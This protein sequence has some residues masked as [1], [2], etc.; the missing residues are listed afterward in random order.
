MKSVSNG[1]WR[2]VSAVVA[3]AVSAAAFVGPQVG[4]SPNPNSAETAYV[5]IAPCR[6]VDTRPE[7]QVGRRGSPIGSNETFAQQVT[8]TNG[9]CTIPVDA[10]GVS[11]NV[12]V[13][14][15]TAPSYM[16]LYPLD[17]PLPRAS[18]LNYLPGGAPAPNK[19]DVKL[20]ADGAIGFYNLAGTVDVVAD[21]NGYYTSA[22]LHEILQELTTKVDA[23]DVFTKSQTYSRRQI[24]NVIDERDTGVLTELDEK[25]DVVEVD[26]AITELR[27]AVD[28]ELEGKVDTSELS[29]VVAG[30]GSAISEKIDTE[31]VYD[32]SEQ[33]DHFMGRMPDIAMRQGT[34][35]IVDLLGNPLAEH[36][37]R[38]ATVTADGDGVVEVTGPAALSH[39]IS[40]LADYRLM[41]VEVCIA[42]VAAASMLDTIT[43]TVRHDDG[44]LDSTAFA[45]ERSTAGCTTTDVSD[46]ALGP[47]YFVQFDVTGTS[48]AVT[49]I[50]TT[51]GAVIPDADADFG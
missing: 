10:T 31:E 40:G 29:A 1:P 48:V 3:A 13:V 41:A 2:G 15:P 51:W 14:D 22:G 23:D 26:A 34:G 49:T 30:L 37:L 6:L 35:A 43:V 44:E 45:V 19:V 21:V 36:D 7:F 20:S 18:N 24:D 5:P 9:D 46:A 12:T 42:D 27:Q 39:S 32:K 38:G 8:G 33:E 50:E 17:T 47:N 16:T 28:T 4:A 25:V 11:L